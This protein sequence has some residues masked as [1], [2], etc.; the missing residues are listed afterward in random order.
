VQAIND[1]LSASVY[2]YLWGETR[3]KGGKKTLLEAFSN[4]TPRRSMI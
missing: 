1:Q 4:C 3:K 2:D